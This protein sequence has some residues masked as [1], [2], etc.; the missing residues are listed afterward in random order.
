MGNSV[1]DNGMW[2]LGSCFQIVLNPDGYSTRLDK[3]MNRHER[4]KLRHIEILSCIFCNTLELYL[5]WEIIS[6]ETA[7]ML[8]NMGHN[9]FEIRN[10][11][12]AEVVR[13]HGRTN[14]I[15]FL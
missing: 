12:K 3:L 1:S 10:H 5:Q 14:I 7:A 6:R 2:S 9:N 4:G 11:R 13:F 15:V 8:L